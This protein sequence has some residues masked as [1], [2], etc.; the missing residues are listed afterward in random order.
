MNLLPA[1]PMLGLAVSDDPWIAFFA[2]L[3]VG[4]NLAVLALWGFAVVAAFGVGRETWARVRASLGDSGLAFTAVVATTAMVGSLY[5]SE[6]AHFVPCLLCWYQRAAMYPLAIILVVAALRRDWGVRPYA[7]ALALIGPIVSIYHYVIERR[8]EL[9]I[10][11]EDT[12][13]AV[14]PSC[15]A[16]YIEDQFG[17]ISIPF[18]ALSAFVL[19]ATVLVLARPD[20]RE[21]GGARDD[22]DG[23]STSAGS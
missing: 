19:V 11:G 5:L 16:R 23:G 9:E 17:Y 8:P 18:M 20:A 6:A 3:A 15:T 7:L 21:G 22:E 4:A 13:S 10:G 14:G 1:T 12:C 2:L